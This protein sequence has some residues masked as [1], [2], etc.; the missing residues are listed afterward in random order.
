LVLALRWGDGG[1]GS[2]VRAATPLLGAGARGFPTDVAMK[3]ASRVAVEWLRGASEGHERAN[4]CE[5]QLDDSISSS[6]YAFEE[7]AKESFG[8][9]TLAFALLEDAL[10]EN[11]ASHLDSELERSGSPS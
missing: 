7:D 8:Y 9:H 6:E 11:L 4:G 1:V 2:A 5:Q 3:V 10:A